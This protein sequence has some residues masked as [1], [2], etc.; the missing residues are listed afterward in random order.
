MKKKTT[1]TWAI[2]HWL[3]QIHRIGTEKECK[4]FCKK[5]RIYHA[6]PLIGIKF[7]V[8]GACNGKG[9]IVQPKDFEDIIHKP[10]RIVS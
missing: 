4:N 5:T 3:G 7:T 1:E 9:K 2:V 8:C 10:H 6:L